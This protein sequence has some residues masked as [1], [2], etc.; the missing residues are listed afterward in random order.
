MKKGVSREITSNYSFPVNKGYITIPKNID[1]TLFIEDCYRREKVIIQIEDGGGFVPNCYISRQA[2]ADIYFPESYNEVGSAVIFVSDP[3]ADMPIVIA[4]ISKENETQLLR[5]NLFKVVKSLNNNN[6][7]IIGDGNTGS[8]FVTVKG[9]SGGK[10]YINLIGEDSEFNLN[11]LGSI[12]VH[13]DGEMNL[14]SSEKF[15]LIVKDITGNKNIT[16][17]VDKSN[18]VTYSDGFGNGFIIDSDGV[19]NFIPSSKFKLFKG[20]KA[21]VLGEETV[22]T[23]NN[24]IDEIINVSDG[25]LTFASA[26]VVAI[27]AVPALAPLAPAYIALVTAIATAIGQLEVLKQTTG[28]IESEKSFLE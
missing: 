22:D 4:T 11:S 2:L 1:R 16:L 20:S 3:Y 5:E 15:T 28:N 27:A 25:L 13:S 23:F 17:E 19:I 7:T 18:G 10:I 26:Q 8:L 14:S 6:V 12:N 24:T 21:M 9:D